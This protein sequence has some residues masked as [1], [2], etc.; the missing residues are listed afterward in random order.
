MLRNW[1]G[2]GRFSNPEVDLPPVPYI[3]SFFCLLLINNQGFGKGTELSLEYF[4][5]I[6]GIEVFSVNL[7]FNSRAELRL[8]SLW[9]GSQGLVILNSN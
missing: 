7:T 9:L 1:W 5:L 2:F 4:L 3:S 8:T 6:G